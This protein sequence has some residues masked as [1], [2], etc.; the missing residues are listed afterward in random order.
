MVSWDTRDNNSVILSVAKDPLFLSLSGFFTTFRMT[1]SPAAGERSAFLSLKQNENYHNMNKHETL[2]SIYEDFHIKTGYSVVIGVE[3][4]FY[5]NINEELSFSEPVQQPAA[6]AINDLN[7]ALSNFPFFSEVEKEK[8]EG[9][10][11]V[12]IAPTDNPAV[13]AK[14]V[15]MLR[16]IILE[17]LPATETQKKISFAAKPFSD[18][19][20]SGMHI[21]INLLDSLGQNAFRRNGEDESVQ[22]NYAVAGLLELMPASMKYFAPY[23]EAYIRYIQHGMDAPSTI[24]WGA[25]NRTTSLRLP[26]VPLMKQARR[27]EHRVPCA[28][29]DPYLSIAAILAG[30]QFGLLNKLENKHPKIWGNAFLPQYALQKLPHSFVEAQSI[31]HEYLDMIMNQFLVAASNNQN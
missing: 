15:E 8:G 19:P 27:I 5:Y 20:G 14:M 12:Q 30:I 25:N 17:T 6:S 4:E 22:L 1:M 13:M 18:Q 29:A 9:Q 24:S 26:S 23:E 10:F 28:D 31:S 16:K 21:H 3:Q 11:E 7:K 2:Q